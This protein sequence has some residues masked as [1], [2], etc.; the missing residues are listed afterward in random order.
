MSADNT[1][2]VSSPG[3]LTRKLQRGQVTTRFSVMVG[4]WF[5]SVRQSGRLYL[6]SHRGPLGG[7]PEGDAVED[8]GG[9]RRRVIQ[10]SAPVEI[11]ISVACQ[12][13]P[14]KNTPILNAEP[15]FG[16]GHGSGAAH[17]R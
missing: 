9:S 16:T 2:V 11:G 8:L 14:F 1:G 15:T 7:L 4:L 17:L 3:S 12:D 10:K 5:R 13:R 6:R